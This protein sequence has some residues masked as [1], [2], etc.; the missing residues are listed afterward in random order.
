MSTKPAIKPIVSKRPRDR[1]IADLIDLRSY[2][3]KNDGL[4]WA[5]IMVD[6]FSKFGWARLCQSKESSVIA[7]IFEDIFRSHGP[8]LI[9]HTDNGGEFKYASLN[10][11]NEKFGIRQIFGR[12]RAPWIQGQCVVS[13]NQLNHG[14]QH[15]QPDTMTSQKLLK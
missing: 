9:L 13:T 6:S 15:H 4:S 7:D 8:P 1:Y 12:A 5:L 10:K 11:I 2:K 14:Y 3:D